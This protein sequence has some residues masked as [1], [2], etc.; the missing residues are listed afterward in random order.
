MVASFA[1]APTSTTALRP[2]GRPDRPQFH[3]IEGGAGRPAPTAM[4]ILR[5]R[6]VVLLLMVTCVVAVAV[7][8]QAALRPLVAS[9]GGGASAASG[10]TQSTGGYTVQP[11]DTLW[12]VAAAIAP[13][14]ADVRATVDELADLNGGPTLAVGQRL[15]LPD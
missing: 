5:R 7:G 2:G 1:P 3:L 9:P 4:V 14:G 13:E 15:A 8:A 11:G 6:L 12:S 10:V